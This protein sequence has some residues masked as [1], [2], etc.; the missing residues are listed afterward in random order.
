MTDIPSLPT[1]PTEDVWLSEPKLDQR[2]GYS[3][4]TLVRLRQRG[5]PHLGTGRRRRYHW[6]SVL[7]WLAL[8]A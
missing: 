4:S 1:I 8:N 2:L 7:T 3:R 5:L 6:P